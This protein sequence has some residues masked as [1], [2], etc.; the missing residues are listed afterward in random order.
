MARLLPL[1]LLTGLTGCRDP[2]PLDP[3]EPPELSGRRVVER[4]GDGRIRW[5]DPGRRP[6]VR[7]TADHPWT[8]DWQPPPPAPMTAFTLV[9]ER[10]DG[11]IF[12]RATGGDPPIG[13]GT[14]RLGIAG[15]AVRAWPVE[16]HPDPDARAPVRAIREAAAAG[17]FDEA[18]ARAGAVVDP[19]D[20]LWTAVEAARAEFKADDLAAAERAWL[21]AA[22]LA[23]E[24]GLT[25]EQSR[26]L[27]AAAHVALVRRAFGAASAY[28]ERAA[29]LDIDDPTGMAQ[30]AHLQGVLAQEL[31]E[32]QRAERAFD[33][34][35]EAAERAADVAQRHRV[36]EAWALLQSDLGLHA[37]ALGRIRRLREAPDLHDAVR[38]R[39]AESEGWMLL[40]AMLDGGEAFE[41][42]RVRA[43]FDA[44]A[45]D[46][47]V[48]TANLAVNRA[49]L[50][51]L[52]GDRAAAG[53][54]LR[55]ARA[56]DPEGQ[57]FAASWIELLAGRLALAEGDP[58]GAEIRFA[59][60]DARVRAELGPDGG[61]LGWRA[62][63]GRARAARAAGDLPRARRWFDQA[64]VRL[65]RVGAATPL[66]Q[67]RAPFFAD[68][69]SL[70]EEAVAAALDAGDVEGAF[71]I[72][73]R[74]RGRLVRG[75]RAVAA[76][77]R[78]TGADQRTWTGLQQALEEAR[79]RLESTRRACETAAADARVACLARQAEAER[80]RIEA[81]D[82]ATGFL[83][84]ALGGP[85]SAPGD[86][87][88]ALRPGEAALLVARR[89]EGRVALWA[90]ADGYST[91]PLPAELHALPPPPAPLAHLYVVGAG[92]PDVVR[93]AVRAGVDG[94]FSVSQLPVAALLH[95]PPT[96]PAT[97]RPLI[98][99]DP[100]WNLPG[101][102]REAKDLYAALPD[103][104]FLAGD[105]ASP[106]V[107]RA[108]LDDT[109][110][111]HYAGHGVL[112]AERPWSAHLVLA[113][114]ARFD[115][116][117][118]LAARMPGSLVV[119]GGCETGSDA[120]ATRDDVLGLPEA[121]LVAGARA[122]VAADRVLPDTEARRFTALFRAYGGHARPGEA[123]RRAMA[124]LRD[125]G[126]ATWDA[127]RL[128]GRPA[129]D[130]PP[131]EPPR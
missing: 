57:T 50:E 70:V 121:F 18:R 30:T 60:L 43:L 26:R 68:R 79:A 46:T 119:L 40:R 103:A 71:S 123:V 10:R 95:A 51:L 120:I 81:F 7:V 24:R 83:D 78:L 104:Q 6:V 113:H 32:W 75:L 101:A 111:F 112:R 128:F 3:G 9:S 127:W 49:W 28:L 64:L 31:A 88:A 125:E 16:W 52:A 45:A 53:R 11:A 98:V 74:A 39:L 21:A 1:V 118:A 115:V 93:A 29:R 84:A 56:A 25:S 65:D 14:L 106:D 117:D 109:P 4:G 2:V 105:A 116:F 85:V 114:G 129:L 94:G 37:A 34:A 8:L 102:R 126:A 58:A 76:I 73:D 15:R 54:H 92:H 35:L 33:R 36:E 38:T 23:A 67:A 22:D 82:A 100:V 110:L 5:F 91:G 69:R 108:A 41:P 48:A 12:L 89:P 131:E 107:V 13:P 17:R 55:A 96:P 47:A 130:A 63:L 99:A 44:A 62:D 59:A 19:D 124:T 77:D 87:R 27:G 122:V 42:A 20:R 90:T 66:R 86:V 80:A 97:G 61:D 72:A